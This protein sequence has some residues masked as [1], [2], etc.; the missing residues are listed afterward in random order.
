MKHQD[1][2]TTTIQIRVTPEEHTQ[3][4]L[5]AVARRQSVSAIIR[6][7]IASTN[8]IHSISDSNTEHIARVLTE[9]E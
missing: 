1:G 6:D 2:R 7:W 8:T 4:R 5:L 9:G 3:M